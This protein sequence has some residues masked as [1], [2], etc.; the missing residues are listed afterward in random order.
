M[1]ERQTAMAGRVAS[2]A[3]RTAEMT[4]L[5]SG[6]PGSG[7]KCGGGR[8]KTPV[9]FVN[10]RVS[11]SASSISAIATSQSRSDQNLPLSASRTTA[12]TRWPADSNARAA[13]PPTLPVIPVIAYM[14][15]LLSSICSRRPS[16]ASR[17]IGRDL[18]ASAP[19]RSDARPVREVVFHGHDAYLFLVGWLM[20][21]LAGCLQRH[22]RD[23][24]NGQAR[25]AVTDD[26]VGIGKHA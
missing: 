25:K 18:C 15:S 11:A 6:N 20:T 1:V 3:R 19:R 4:A 23:G 12:R 17:A 9:T 13:T 8:M 14:R 22:E 16:A 21:R 24:C 10:A 7:S 5:A 2:S 26:E